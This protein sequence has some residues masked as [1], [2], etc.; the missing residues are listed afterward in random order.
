[1]CGLGDGHGH[2]WNSQVD[3]ESDMINKIHGAQASFE[4]QSTE[5]IAGSA[6]LRTTAAKVDDLILRMNDTEQTLLTKVHGEHWVAQLDNFAQVMHKHETKMAQ[7][8]REF[9]MRIM[10]EA[11]MRQELTQNLSC[12]VRSTIEKTVPGGKDIS[13]MDE[14]TTSSMGGVT[15]FNMNR[16]MARARSPTC[17]SLNS[18]V[19]A[20]GIHGHSVCISPTMLCNAPT[21]LGIT[22]S[23]S[24]LST[25]TSLVPANV[26]Q[27]GRQMS[28]P[29][30]TPVAMLQHSTGSVSAPSQRSLSPL[31]ANGR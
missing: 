19:T 25:A 24:P 15:L 20:N 30:V 8:E 21:H 9:N 18:V 26:R 6:D 13:P 2:K 5:R 17:G 14:S 16:G 4:T 3:K 12:V 23:H 31:R 1:M 29:A 11:A 22:A 10:Q 28:V 27:V 7:M